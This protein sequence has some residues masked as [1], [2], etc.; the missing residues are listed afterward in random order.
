MSSWTDILNRP[1]LLAMNG[2]MYDRSSLLKLCAEHS[3]DIVYNRLTELLNDQ[4]HIE[5][6][7]SGSTG[8]PKS[9]KVTKEKLL[10]SALST[11]EALEL[12]N[13]ANLALCISCAH[14]GGIMMLVRALAL[15]AE[16]FCFPVS[17]DPLKAIDNEEIDLVALV[18]LQVSNGL[19]STAG[20]TRLAQMKNVIIGGAPL[21]AGIARE[22]AKFP[23]AIYATFG[24]TETLS[25]IAL[26]RLSE[27]V[28]EA[29][30]CVGPT[31][32]S[33]DNEE[34]LTIHARHLS[35]EPIVTNDAVELISETKF[36]WKG[37]L[38][39]VIN[40]GGIKLY[41]EQLEKKLSDR[42]SERFFFASLPD[43]QL[44]RALI[45]CIEGSERHIEIQD[46]LDK[47]E[48][49]K[50]I[51]F[52]QRFVEAANGKIDRSASIDQL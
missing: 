28:E 18:P 15:G 31:T 45:L 19:K 22:L 37:R 12:Q 23:N 20:R 3:G 11:I 10:A 25:H 5:V 30:S 52:M 50:S 35:D 44:G 7:T 9:I 39:H 16:L 6:H 42:I 43:P 38:D 24:M 4:D 46:L 2:T 47:Y 48:Q 49:P 40:S 14:I 41:P 17:A 1:E 51:R 8:E 26:Q 29:F 27:P 34:R 32:L 13:G 36:I 33:T 21:E